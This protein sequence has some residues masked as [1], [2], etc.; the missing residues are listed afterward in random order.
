MDISIL[1]LT[2]LSAETGINYFKLYRKFRAGQKFTL[3]ERTAII[4][5]LN[6]QLKP[7][8]KDLGFELSMT[9]IP[10]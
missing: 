10:E 2:T 7:L 9:R 4:K 5:A 3:D 8:T 1:N 6:R